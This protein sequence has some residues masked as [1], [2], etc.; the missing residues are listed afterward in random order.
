VTANIELELPARSVIIDRALS[1]YRYPP[2]PFP[3]STLDKPILDRVQDSFVRAL[4][5]AWIRR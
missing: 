2:R 4:G 1:P 3:R 5:K